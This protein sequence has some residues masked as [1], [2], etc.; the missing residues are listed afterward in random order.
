MESWF[1]NIWFRRLWPLV[2][3]IGAIVAYDYYS[4][5]RA[6]LEVRRENQMA[7]ITAKLWVASAIYRHDTTRYD[8]YRDSILT[9]TGLQRQH[10]ELYMERYRGEDVDPSTF[11]TLVKAKIDSLIRMETG[12]DTI[13]VEPYLPDDT[14]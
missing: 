11:A 6:A 10:I 9:A 8:E 5:Q 4:K 13:R 14:L 3:I 12:E 2:V 1:H 7:L